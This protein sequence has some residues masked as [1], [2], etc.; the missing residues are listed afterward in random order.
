VVM[1]VH[2][3]RGPEVWSQ[4]GDLNSIPRWSEFTRLV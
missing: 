3:V 1:V 2:L 4:L